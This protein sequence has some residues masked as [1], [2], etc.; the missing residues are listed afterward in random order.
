MKHP[1]TVRVLGLAV[2]FAMQRLFAPISMGSESST[3][4]FSG[5][6]VMRSTGQVDLDGGT[7]YVGDN[8]LLTRA[9]SKNTVLEK[10]QPKNVK[11]VFSDGSSV[12]STALVSS[13]TR[14]DPSGFTITTQPFGGLLNAF[15]DLDGQTATLTKTLEFAAG[16]WPF[17]GII[18]VNAQTLRMNGP[19]IV[20]DPVTFVN[21]ADIDFNNRFTLTDTWTFTGDGVVTG[22][23]GIIDL[24]GGGVLFIH[25]NTSLSLNNFVLK[26]V[27]SGSIVFA[28]RTSQL[29]LA[30]MQVELAGNCTFT[31]GGFYVEGPTTIVTADKTFTLATASSMTVDGTSLFYDTLSFADQQN[32][33]PTIAADTNHK[34]MISLNNGV[35]RH[36]DSPTQGDVHYAQ[37]SYLSGLTVVHPNRKIAFDQSVT[38]D[39][40]TFPL[41][42]SQSTVPLVSVA[43]GKTAQIQNATLE[44]F[45]PSFVSLGSGGALHFGDATRIT[46]AKNEDLTTTFSFRGNCAINGAGHTLT[47]GDAGALIVDGPHGALLLEN[48]QI[49]NLSGHQIRCTDNTCTVSLNNVRFVLDGSYSL[50][51]GNFVVLRGPDDMDSG[52]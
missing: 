21:A 45:C 37:N 46:F 52:E 44:Y 14:R 3:L 25:P 8:L 42:F 38:L 10:T 9:A 41:I 32:I 50:T 20:T 11:I 19:S 40:Q 31:T 23:G 12:A 39:G 6:A 2:L 17:N 7:L 30:N 15:L 33:S 48:M 13:I 16:Y 24:S 49:K 29:R 5:S 35:L 51:N 43:A 47:L 27:S 28:D 1:Q 18:N 22:N 36:V 26:G 34:R 4:Q